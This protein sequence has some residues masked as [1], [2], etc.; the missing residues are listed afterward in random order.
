[1][2]NFKGFGGGGGMNVQQMMKQAQKMQQDLANI[3]TQLEEAELEG[4]SGGGVVSVTVN[5]KKKVLKVSIKPEAVDPE[6]V[7]ILEDLI[8]A[9]INDACEKAEDYE[10][11]INPYSGMM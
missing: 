6:D 3:Q 10:K 1:M 11:E 2:A 7:E 8:L 9:A 5:G 4:S